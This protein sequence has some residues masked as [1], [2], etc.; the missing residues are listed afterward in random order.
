M[1]TKHLD[2]M[3]NEVME[4][5]LLRTDWKSQITIGQHETSAAKTDPTATAHEHDHYQG[6]IAGVKSF[7]KS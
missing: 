5:I 3:A 1:N 4:M 6:V 7:V 2:N